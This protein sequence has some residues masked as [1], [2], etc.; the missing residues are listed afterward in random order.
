MAR[1][2][3]GAGVTRGH[4][5]LAH[6]IR[7]R[8]FA[9]GIATLF[10]SACVVPREETL[11][12]LHGGFGENVWVQIDIRSTVGP[13]EVRFVEPDG[14]TAR[15]CRTPCSM[16]L[17]NNRYEMVSRLVGSAPFDRRP[18]DVDW[19]HIRIAISPP[20]FPTQTAGPLAVAAGAAGLV[21]GVA[22]IAI[23]APSTQT[24]CGFDIFT[25][26]RVCATHEHSAS[27]THIVGGAI[28]L[29]AGAALFGA[30]LAMIGRSRA[31]IVMERAP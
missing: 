31:R 30:G 13:L 11:G 5:A 26:R 12:T 20:D 15:V 10:T 21:A 18:V 25:D 3:Q 27:S 6:S 19:G 29:V 1:V 28:S 7:T 9:V 14:A 16:S 8:T 17:P 24:V 2:T 22:A 4:M 23:G